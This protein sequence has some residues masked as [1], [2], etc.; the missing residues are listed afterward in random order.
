LVLYLILL[1]AFFNATSSGVDGS[2]VG[3]INAERQYEAFFH[4]KEIESST[5]IVFILYN[6]ASMIDLEDTTTLLFHWLYNSCWG[7]VRNI[8]V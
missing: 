1:V 6:A 3:C 4:L 8:F 5:G 2:L 7:Y